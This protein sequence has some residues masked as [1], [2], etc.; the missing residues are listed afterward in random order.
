MATGRR[1]Q[2]AERH[3]ANAREPARSESLVLKKIGTGAGAHV[4]AADRL[5]L[6]SDRRCRQDGRGE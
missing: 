4:E 6:S 5:G 3:A 2:H 1:R